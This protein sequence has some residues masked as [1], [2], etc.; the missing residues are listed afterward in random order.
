[1]WCRLLFFKLHLCPICGLFPSR[2]SST[3][4]Y[5]WTQPRPD[6]N[7]SSLLWEKSWQHDFDNNFRALAS[8]PHNISVLSPIEMSPLDH[9]LVHL[10]Y[11]V[12][13]LCQLQH[14]LAR[15]FARRSAEERFEARWKDAA[16]DK[17]Q[18]AILEGLVRTMAIPDMEE[19]RKWCPDST[20]ETLNGH[21]GEGF[22]RVIRSLMSTDLSTVHTEPVLPSHPIADRVMT[23]SAAQL[24]LPRYKIAFRAYRISRAYCLTS[25][26]W[27]IFLAFVSPLDNFHNTIWSH[28]NEILAWTHGRPICVAQHA[29]AWLCSSE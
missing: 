1:M 15:G 22:L 16:P 24:E 20:L 26:A 11:E 4:K 6:I 3:M 25:I 13:L 18:E 14:D 7:S 28:A 8:L 29:R 19:R 5:S 23:P 27:N 21:E 9:T 12:R 10:E 17:R 2:L